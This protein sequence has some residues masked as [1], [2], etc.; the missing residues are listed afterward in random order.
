MCNKKDQFYVPDDYVF[1]LPW[2]RI[3]NSDE[4]DRLVA[5]L[6]IE[7]PQLADAL[8]LAVARRIDNG[9]VLFNFLEANAVH[10]GGFPF[11]MVHLTGSGKHEPTLG[12]RIGFFEC[13]SHWES[14]WFR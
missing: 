10:Q 2:M 6:L 14:E 9:E 5:E 7:V 1:A 12:E 11:G 3:S 4:A 13:W 8:P